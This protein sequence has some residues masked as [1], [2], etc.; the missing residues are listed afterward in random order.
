M[1]AVAARWAPGPVA[2]IAVALLFGLALAGCTGDNPATTEPR[3]RSGSDESPSPS[4]KS[5]KQKRSPAPRIEH[6]P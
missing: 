6:A 1:P 2:A 4:K 3:A 5:G